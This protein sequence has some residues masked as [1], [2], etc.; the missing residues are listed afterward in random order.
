[1]TVIFMRC[2]ILLGLFK[3]Y[4]LDA[5]SGSQMLLFAM[6]CQEDQV[7][8]IRFRSKQALNQTIV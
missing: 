2:L 3:L 4:Q 6:L 5:Q 7:L 1:M 8:I